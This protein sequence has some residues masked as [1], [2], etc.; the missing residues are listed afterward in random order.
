MRDRGYG[1]CIM[2]LSLLAMVTSERLEWPQSGVETQPTSL[3]G[4]PP[5]HA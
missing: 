2:G 5:L 4:S 3:H 1:V